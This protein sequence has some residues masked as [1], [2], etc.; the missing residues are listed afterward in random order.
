MNN[1]YQNTKDFV[2]ELTNR[3]PIY[4]V[5]GKGS[6]LYD[7]KGKKYLDFLCGV[8]V[9]SF[10]HAHRDLV[11]V[12]QKQATKLL[13]TSNW[14][15]ISEQAELAKELVSLFFRNSGGV[16]GGDNVYS[17][18]K[19]LLDNVKDG[20]GGGGDSNASG[21]GSVEGG[22]NVYSPQKNL[23]DNVKDGIGGGE[24]KYSPQKY[25][26]DNV[27]DG[28]GGGGD[29]N[30][31]GS[32]GGGESKYSPQKYLLDNVKDGIGG[33]GGSNASGGG[34]DNVYSPQK[35][36]LDNVKDGSGGGGGSNES[37]GVGGGESK[38]SPQKY[39]L[40][41]VKDGIGGGGS[42]TKAKVFFFNSGTEANEAAFKLSRSF[43]QKEKGG[44]VEIISLF[45]SFHGR[46]TASICLTGQEK[47]H[48]GFGQLLNGNIYLNRNDTPALE[49]VFE[50]NS[51]NLCA[52][53]IELIQGEGG[54][55]P[56]D[57]DYV[58][59]ARELC[60]KH[61]VLLVIDEVQTGVGRTGTFFC[62]EQYGITPD[63]AT[64][65]KALGGGLPIA[66]MIVKDEFTKFL[67]KGQHGTTLGGNPFC[68]KVALEVLKIIDREKILEHVKIISK[69]IFEKLDELSKKYKIITDIR[70]KGLHIGLTIETSATEFVKLCLEKGLI[71]NATSENSIRI[72]PPLN[73]KM[74]E[75]KLGLEILEDAL[76]SLIKL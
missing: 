17:P 7:A 27:K 14:F 35:N 50:K 5:K 39:L 41:N 54:I 31:S 57:I 36:L 13:H 62:F 75:A 72:M 16:G 22:D 42:N 43:G 33:D 19:N 51:K 32:V 76:S 28:I 26:L 10:G 74:K 55:R 56:L 29:S 4:F 66:A 70:G 53:F 2:L 24:S 67:Q 47:I 68:M 11:K 23:L 8:S 34:G 64:L 59:K 58:K 65:A 20:I 73:L 60:T 18:Q 69:Y 9:T 6:Y 61:K 3:H 21:G 52:L 37:G 63:I 45:N 25:L 49:E 30:A 40:D 71:L 12:I 38:Y 44:A 15:H 1:T 46:T 48:K